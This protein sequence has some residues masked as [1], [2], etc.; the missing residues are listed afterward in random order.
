M[1]QVQ[2]CQWL[3]RGLAFGGLRPLRAGGAVEG[4]EVFDGGG[5]V[6]HILFK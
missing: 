2:Y 3:V 1:H 6:G 4:G 5:K